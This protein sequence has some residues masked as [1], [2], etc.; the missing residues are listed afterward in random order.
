MEV[1]LVFPPSSETQAAVAAPPTPTIA[2]PADTKDVL[3]ASPDSTSHF[4][5]KFK[6]QQQSSQPPPQQQ[7]QQ[8]KA[9]PPSP[10][11]RG[12]GR[13]SA[14][15]AGSRSNSNSPVSSPRRR[16]SFRALPSP[17][18]CGPLALKNDTSAAILRGGDSTAPVALRGGGDLTNYD[19]PVAPEVRDPNALEALMWPEMQALLEEQV[20]SIKKQHTSSAATVV[21]RLRGGE[22]A[23]LQLNNQLNS[24]LQAVQQEQQALAVRGAAITTRRKKRASS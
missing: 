11:S 16:G 23:E 21:E 20:I 3:H 22:G 14:G 6:N 4:T 24:Q 15:S 2:A 13:G 8:R 10:T 1:R 17:P 5:L 19:D 12:R 7:Q 18:E 9:T